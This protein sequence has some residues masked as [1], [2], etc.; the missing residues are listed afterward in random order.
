MSQ[1]LHGWNCVAATARLPRSAAVY[2]TNEPTAA[3]NSSECAKELQGKLLPDL[4]YSIEL[5]SIL[6][7]LLGIVVF[8]KQPRY[9][10]NQ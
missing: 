1:R 9:I 8:P 7:A 3:R 10:L 5:K 2:L 4:Y 6:P